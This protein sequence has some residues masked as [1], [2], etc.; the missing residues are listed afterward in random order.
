MSNLRQ[1]AQMALE[2]LESYGKSAY[3]KHE[4]PKRLANGNKAAEALR[5]ALA[6]AQEP[7]AWVNQEFLEEVKA[8]GG[9]MFVTLLD[10]DTGGMM[11]L[12]THPAPAAQ[13][14]TDEQIHQEFHERM[15]ADAEDMALDVLDFKAGVRFAERAH[16][17]GGN[18]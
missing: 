7:V 18:E 12:Y 13:P 17:I 14:L 8:D 15:N 3:I 5:A 2:A 6:A 1:A 16:G 9:A 11:P 10:K 4:H